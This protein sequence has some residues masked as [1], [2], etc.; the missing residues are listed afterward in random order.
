MFQVKLFNKIILF[1]YGN[2]DNISIHEEKDTVMQNIVGVDEAGRGPWA[3]PVVVAAVSLDVNKPILGLDDSKKLSPKKRL[4]LYDQII[5]SAAM[6]SYIFIRVATIDNINIRAATL[7]GMQKAIYKLPITPDIALIDGKDT[8]N[9]TCNCEAI[10]GGD[11]KIAEIS[12]ASI[13]AKVLRDR[14]MERLAAA[15]PQYG[16]EKHKGYGTKIHQ[17]AIRDYGITMHHRKS[18]APIAK[19]VNSGKADT[20]EK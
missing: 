14:F 16:F 4:L 2:D 17:E 6:Y 8:P 3:G 1:V 9:V 12:A 13:L 18:F 7:L 20:I 5:N 19:L 15:Y 11:A 10:I